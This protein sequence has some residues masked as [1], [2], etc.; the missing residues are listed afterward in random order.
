MRSP[1]AA[2]PG[3]ET[4]TA[5]CTK[6]LLRRGLVVFGRL[7]PVTGATEVNP[8][9]PQTHQAAETAS[10]QQKRVRPICR[11]CR[12]S[13]R[14]MTVGPQGTADFGAIEQVFIEQIETG[15]WVVS[16]RKDGKGDPR[17]WQ[18]H[19]KR[20]RYVPA[21]GE[22]PTIYLRSKDAEGP[23]SGAVEAPVGTPIFRTLTAAP[24]ATHASLFGQPHPVDQKESDYRN[25]SC[26]ANTRGGCSR[27]KSG[28]HF[29]SHGLI[30]LYTFDD[31]DVKIKH[32]TGY[33]IREFV[34]PKKFVS[35]ILCRN[36]NTALGSAD[37]TALE[38]AR[39]IRR[40]AL[41]FRNGAGKW[42]EDEEITISGENLQIWVLKLILNH[43]VGK[44][45]NGVKV[46]FPPEAVD[47]LLRRAMWPRNWGLCV[48]GDVSHEELR[49]RPFDRLEDS[50]TEWCSFQPLFHKEGWVGGGIVNLNGIGF[51]LTVFD[52]SRDHP[53]AFDNNPLN[54]LRGSIL[55]PGF[56]AWELG[57][58]TKRVNFEWDDVWDHKTVAY[59]MLGD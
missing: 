36:H 25:P 2:G 56:M 44:A 58:T 53:E 51:G 6:A 57:G 29:I 11:W 45:F 30:K 27:G 48:A 42:G 26:Y 39:F 32:D 41:D 54:P 43:A 1:L 47:L 37:A 5:H 28:E 10:P 35:N 9:A 23:A 38:F 18:V 8:N 52:P 55:R 12:T 13:I 22:P 24:P 33:G 15:D 46:E 50:T 49:F 31:P 4:P 34:S 59:K 21:S 17:R 20:F 19:A 16:T 14:A 7:L 3:F 40:I